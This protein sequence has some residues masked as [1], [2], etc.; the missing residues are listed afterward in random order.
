MNIVSLVWICNIHRALIVYLVVTSATT[1]QNFEFQSVLDK[2]IHLFNKTLSFSV[3]KSLLVLAAMTGHQ[4]F[5]IVICP[6]T[7]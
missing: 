7:K 3:S 2:N 5:S 6:T 4:C 1:V